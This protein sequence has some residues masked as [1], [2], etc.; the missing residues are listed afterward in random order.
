MTATNPKNGWH[1]VCLRLDKGHTKNG[2]KVRKEWNVESPDWRRIQLNLF[3]R[4]KYQ[5]FRNIW[6]HC[7]IVCAERSFIRSLFPFGEW[8][9]ADPSRLIAKRND[10]TPIMS[11]GMSEWK[12]LFI[13]LPI[14]FSNVLSTFCAIVRRPATEI[15]QHGSPFKR[16]KTVLRNS[17]TK[18]EAVGRKECRIVDASCELV[19][20]R[21]NANSLRFARRYSSLI[22]VNEKRCPP[23]AHQSET[24]SGEEE[25]TAYG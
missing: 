17:L 3:S 20:A 13:C 16:W 14:R 23:F 5:L 9:D 24:R 6:I 12:V 1:S 19:R 11:P 7:D 21:S 8:I 22:F 18:S 25:R 15:N 4:V 2:P 10:I